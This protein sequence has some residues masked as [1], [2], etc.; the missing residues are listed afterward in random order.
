MEFSFLSLEAQAST[1]FS[2]KES[3]SLGTTSSG[4]I[5]RLAP[6]PLQD[7]QAPKG[8]LKENILGESSSIPIPW[9]GQANFVEKVISSPSIIEIIIRP[10]VSFRAVSMESFSLLSIP[11]FII[12]LSIITSILCFLFLSRSMSSPIS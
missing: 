8:E 11:S 9:S 1:A 10:S 5:L 2:L 7:S 3:S 12:N 6:K 4:I